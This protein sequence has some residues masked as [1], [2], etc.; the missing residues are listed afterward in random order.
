MRVL[1]VLSICDHLRT[2]GHTIEDRPLVDCVGALIPQIHI[3][4]SNANPQ[5]H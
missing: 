1:S 3:Q 5:S 4:W 2:M